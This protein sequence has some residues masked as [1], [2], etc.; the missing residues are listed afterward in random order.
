MNAVHVNTILLINILNE[1]GYSDVEFA[2]EGRGQRNSILISLYNKRDEIEYNFR[3]EENDDLFYLK[4]D[5][6]KP[7]ENFLGNMK[8]TKMIKYNLEKELF[9]SNN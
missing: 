9:Y 2:G 8:D 1:L 5:K 4:K 7:I 3:L 6:Y